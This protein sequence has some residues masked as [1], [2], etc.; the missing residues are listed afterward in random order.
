MT[1]GS[2]DATSLAAFE[3]RKYGPVLLRSCLEKISEYVAAT[4]DQAER[5]VEEAPPAY[6]ST[7]LFAVAPL[8]L[9]EP[10]IAGIPGGVVHGEQTFTW[11]NAIPVEADLMVAGI[12]NKVRERGELTYL[13]FDLMVEL[14]GSTLIEGNSTFL[15]MSREPGQSEEAPEPGPQDRTFAPQ[16]DGLSSRRLA[17]R[18]DLIRYAAASRDWNPIH[19]DHASAVAAGLPGIVCHG[20]LMAS[21]LCQV[22]TRRHPSPAPI[23]YG[24]FRFRSPVRPGQEVEITGVADGDA[25][26]LDLKAGGVPCVSANLIHR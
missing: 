18:T 8:L 4:G 17:T 19:W 6:A 22:V 26:R 9:G 25:Y 7:A 2:R 12:V 13:G 24:R 20:L 1:V 16:F 11:H 21:W 10:E 3:G 5:W 14:D 23:S 15:V